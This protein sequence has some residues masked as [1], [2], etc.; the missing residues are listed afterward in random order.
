M[1][2]TPRDMSLFQKN[3]AT[4]VRRQLRAILATDSDDI[5]CV[6][7]NTGVQLRLRRNCCDEIDAAGRQTCETNLKVCLV[8][9]YSSGACSSTSTNKL[10]VA[11]P[12]IGRTDGYIVPELDYPDAWSTPIGSDWQVSGPSSDLRLPIKLQDYAQFRVYSY[13]EPGIYTI[14][15]EL[16]FG[17]EFGKCRGTAEIEVY[18]DKCKHVYTVEWDCVLEAFGDVE[19]VHE[20]VGG[21][22]CLED[23]DDEWVKIEETSTGC[24]YQRVLCGINC[25]GGT[26]CSEDAPDPG[27]PDEDCTCSATCRHVFD[28]VYT[29]PDENGEGGGFGEVSHSVTCVDGCEDDTG[30]WDKVD[31]SSG[32]SCSY[33]R[34]ICEGNCAVDGDCTTTPDPGL[35]SGQ[36][37]ECFPAYYCR[38]VAKYESTDVECGDCKFASGSAGTYTWYNYD[39]STSVVTQEEKDDDEGWYDGEVLVEDPASHTATTQY[40]TYIYYIG[41]TGEAGCPEELNVPAAPEWDPIVGDATVVSV[42]GTWKREQNS[43][44]AYSQRV[45]SFETSFQGVT[46]DEAVFNWSGGYS[47]CSGSCS[48]AAP[49][50]TCDFST[51]SCSGPP[52]GASGNFLLSYDC[53]SGLWKFGDGSFEFSLS[54]DCTGASGDVGYA[55]V[56]R[57]GQWGTECMFDVVFTRA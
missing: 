5:Y 3:F 38:V 11:A 28:V 47:A 34:I 53:T 27:L 19:V 23:D 29:C 8:A 32:A 10:R 40:A 46:D 49:P 18:T 31:E 36:D 56:N 37:C 6:P 51:C 12:S 42:S 17:E 45:Y 7:T 41:T 50:G 20:C 35:P 25:V 44:T 57:G 52:S 9:D 15:Y 2:L 33:Q 48:P 55:L 24:K 54:G 26:D 30:G 39:T 16:D 14:S 4:E 1:A 21:D 43:G 13:T 22:E